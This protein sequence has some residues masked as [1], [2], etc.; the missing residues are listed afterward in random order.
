MSRAAVVF[1]GRGSGTP[2]PHAS[3]PVRHAW[4]GRADELREASGLSPLSRLAAD[5]LDPAV[6]LRPANAW[7]LIFLAGLLDAER[8]AEDHEAVVVTASS[9]GWYTALAATGV[10][11]F[12]DAFRLVQRMAL[13][14]DGPLPGGE[15]PVEIVFPLADE[16]W[17]S[18]PERRDRLNAV[19]DG[20]E[21][22]AHPTL[23]LGAYAVIAGTAEAIDAV[24]TD[25]GP[26][27]VSGRAYPLRLPGADAW[28][29]PLRAASAAAAAAELSD[30]AWAVPSVTLV[31]GRG[32]RSTPWSADPAELARYTLEELPVSRYDVATAVRVA[33]REHAPDVLLVPGPAGSLGAACA[34]LV[35]AEGYRGIRSRADFEEAQRSDAP[36]LLSM[37]R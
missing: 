35:V 24:A 25:L 13:A 4:V 29:T 20:R 3:L 7:P 19:L 23:D 22:P 14:A 27:T 28:H 34:H 37:R 33:L 11:A 8:I 21:R 32:V 36:V 6:H 30:L 10:L 18:D 31:D 1:P 5:Q 17:R 2:S 12:D 16:A 26:V 15:Q 9:T